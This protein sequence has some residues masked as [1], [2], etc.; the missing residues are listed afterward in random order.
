MG[1]TDF[2]RMQ[3]AFGN[4]QPLQVTADDNPRMTA[5]SPSY[6]NPNVPPDIFSGTRDNSPSP[7][8]SLAAPSSPDTGP[9]GEMDFPSTV[10]D[11]ARSTRDMD[12]L[13]AL[14][15]QYPSREN[16]KP[17]I[18]RRIGS[19]LVGIDQ[20]AD[21]Q[22]RYL[23]SGFN[24]ALADW[25]NKVQP[26][27]NL[28]NLERYGN[29]SQQQGTLQQGR[30]NVAQAAEERKS[31]YGGRKLDIDQQKVDASQQ[32]ADAND[33]K[34]NHVISMKDISDTERAA[35][36]NRYTTERDKAKA[37]AAQALQATKG[38]QK[39]DQIDTQ[40]DVNRDLQELR[41]TQ[42]TGQIA[43]TGEEARKT[44]V[45]PASPSKTTQSETQKKVGVQNRA[46]ELIRQNPEWDNYIHIDTNTGQV[47]V[48]PV[49]RHMWEHGPD[50]DTYN[51][52]VSGLEAGMNVVDLGTRGKDQPSGAGTPNNTDTKPAGAG[53]PNNTSEKP[54][55]A[56]TPNKLVTTPSSG[57]GKVRVLA[58]DGK[59]TGTWDLSKGP[60]PKGFKE[61]S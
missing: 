13:R 33:R 32:R 16:Y 61:I 60:I 10:T 53:T 38:T 40:G 31:E 9:Q 57:G 36:M 26:A 7:P 23:D 11:N 47:K 56:G 30:L 50:Q 3:N 24:E 22:S 54:S 6:S 1:I 25:R 20:G 39:I 19:A 43:A 46:A 34:I 37:E 14:A 28:A 17:G 49:S 4:P 48:D 42:K 12:A 18:M 8:E 55:G 51:Q 41:G 5:M 2:F 29:T 52:I 45:A 15:G 59:T 58:P 35:L 44:K 21:A 27:E